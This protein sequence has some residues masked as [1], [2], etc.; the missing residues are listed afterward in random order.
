MAVP[1]HCRDDHLGK[2]RPLA[3]EQLHV[4]LPRI[5]E[6]VQPAVFARVVA[7]VSR[8]LTAGYFGLFQRIVLVPDDV[9]SINAAINS[10]ARRDGDGRGLV[11]IRPGVYS[12][13]VRVTQNCWILGI[14]APGRVVVEAPGWESALVFS[15]LGVRGFGSGEDAY[16]GNVSF[17][18]RN[19]QMRGRCVYIV[20][21]QPLIDHCVIEGGVVVGGGKTAPHFESCCVHGSW[22]NGVHFTDHCRPSLRD[23]LVVKNRQHGVLVDRSSHPEIISCTIR[24]NAACG[25]RFFQ[26]DCVSTAALAGRPPE[27]RSRKDWPIGL[28]G[29]IAG[30]IL[31]DNAGGSFSAT[32]RFADGDEQ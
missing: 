28:L 13:S 5:F 19:E 22:G 3:P 26:G 4:V 25:I 23:S 12:E 8:Q 6:Y 2:P 31:E 1:L 17:R 15:G 27:A 29:R 21:G 9:P 16:V 7:A 11:L 32:P 20:L 30:N 18:C 24:D 10:L 14:G